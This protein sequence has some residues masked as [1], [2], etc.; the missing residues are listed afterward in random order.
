[1]CACVRDLTGYWVVDTVRCDSNG[2]P[3]STLRPLPPHPAAA[4]PRSLLFRAAAGAPP[5]LRKRGAGEAE[6]GEEEEAAEEAQRWA[7]GAAAAA[8]A[9]ARADDAADAAAAAEEA[10]A[11]RDARLG[12]G[13][14]GGGGG[15]P[16]GFG[17]GGAFDAPPPP[18]RRLPP[19]PRGD[20]VAVVPCWTP[21]FYRDQVVC[22]P[23]YK[24]PF[25]LRPPASE[26]P[27]FCG[28]PLRRAAALALLLLPVSL[29][30]CGLEASLDDAQAASPPCVPLSTALLRRA[31][32]VG[33]ITSCFAYACRLC[34]GAGL[35]PPLEGGV[36]SHAAFWAAWAATAAA[37]VG[38]AA[39]VLCLQYTASS[40]LPAITGSA[41]LSFG[42]YAGGRACGATEPRACG[43]DAVRRVASLWGTA[44]GIDLL[45]VWPLLCAASVALW[46]DG[47]DTSSSTQQRG[48]GGAPAG[49]TRMSEGTEL[50]A[51]PVGRVWHNA[52]F[53]PHDDL[54]HDDPAEREQKPTRAAAL[55]AQVNN[56]GAW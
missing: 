10:A 8:E 44:V 25:A 38:L 54:P 56:T 39:W 7:A 15:G 3:L 20:G 16:L 35:L 33:V 21:L 5:A 2:A 40:G 4:A 34:V 17:T 30:L 50:A 42:N 46:H 27:P 24:L 29:F 14:G 41:P 49:G 28:C 51:Q 1:M 18:P 45:L 37:A 23:V 13:G 11:A 52:A 47:A 12:N 19:R 55:G 22:P 43:G 9:A 31:P 32:A 26:W 6:E 53:N 48:D 36:P